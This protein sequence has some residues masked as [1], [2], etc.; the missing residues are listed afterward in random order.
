MKS[1]Q[2]IDFSI[3]KKNK[4]VNVIKEFDAPISKVWSAWTESELLDK[5]W[6]P[7]PWKS[8]TK[9]MDFRIGGFWLYAMVGPNGEEI[10]GREDYKSIVPLKRI[11]AQDAFTDSEGNVDKNF[12]RTNWKMDFKTSDNST[13][14][15][16]E[17][18]YD[19][20][21]DLRRIIEMGFKEGFI[22]ALENLDNLLNHAGNIHQFT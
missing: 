13:I 21:S 11:M 10:W 22:Q 14:V 3:D 7:K 18:T 12:P 15:E 5:W 17:L 1:S 19:K 8:K 2:L 20:S 6:A 9:T 4:K 16:I